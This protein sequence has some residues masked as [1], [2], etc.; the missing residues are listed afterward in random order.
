VN[1]GSGSARRIGIDGYNLVLPKG[2]GI[3]HYGFNLATCLNDAGYAVDGLF[4]LHVGRDPKLREALFFNA[5]GKPPTAKL[6]YGGLARRQR[7]L[8]AATL[9]PWLT[10]TAVR[11]PLS[12]K[13][14]KQDLADRFPPFERLWSVD[15]LFSVAQRHFI[16][17]GRFLP[18]RVAD[19]PD[20]MH[21]TYAIPARLENS[22]NI[23]TVHDLVP[24]RLPYTT[25]GDKVLFR[26]IVEGC[27]RHGDRI[28]TISNFCRDDIV[29][30]FDVA[31]DFVVNTYQ[32]ARLPPCA[33]EPETDAETIVEQVLGLKRDGYYLYYGAI[34]PKKNVGR[35]VEAFLQSDVKAPLVL[36][37]SR[38]WLSEPET[39]LLDHHLGAS[40]SSPPR[41]I[42][43]EYL[44]R[45]MLVRL[46]R[47]ARAMLFPSISEGFGLP[48]LES[49]QLGTPVLTADRG[50][51]AEVAGG[52]ALLV[53]PYDVGAITQGIRTVDASAALRQELAEA[54]PIRAAFFSGDAYLERLKQLYRFN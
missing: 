2:T 30:Q 14:D 51:M 24:L 17:T 15:G 32:T 44:S 29:G 48:I 16:A 9:H 38:A 26:K 35:L 10:K 36:V 39:A 50:A 42:L 52:A 4:G 1:G 37:G 11:V 20:V 33:A 13:V 25:L 3:A 8:L 34:E 31:P 40:T 54:G 28:A 49:M 23:Y 22:R 5:F 41:L 7:Q 19:P 53:D 46:I 45:E 21:W 6:L 18:I 27:M 47:M 43:L 12:A